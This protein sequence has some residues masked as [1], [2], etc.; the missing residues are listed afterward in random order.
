M[1]R[2]IAVVLSIMG[3]LSVPEVRAAD[4]PLPPNICVT[5]TCP[6]PPPKTDNAKTN[7]FGRQESP[8]LKKTAR[9]GTKALIAAKSE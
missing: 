1:A 7:R 6:W 2:I 4:L 3:A 5:P 9:H 8:F